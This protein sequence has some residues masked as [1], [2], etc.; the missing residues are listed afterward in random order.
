MVDLEFVYSCFRK[1]QSVAKSRPYRLP[2]DWDGFYN[3]RLADQNKKALRVITKFF[4]T[5]WS[6]IDVYK[7][8]ECGFE[9]FNNFSYHHFLDP[10]VI[11]LY[12]QRDKIVKIQ[13]NLSKKNIVDSVKFVKQYMKDNNIRFFR[14]YCEKKLPIR[15]YIQNK[16]DHFFLTWLIRDGL[17]TL[18]HDD[19]SQIPYIMENYRETAVKLMEL[20]PFLKKLKEKL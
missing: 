2:K 1:T 19:K 6:K 3:N 14:V 11:R 20:E 18:E 7:Y 15:H 13:T 4:N 17:V 8:F 12:I 10:R 16:I 9:L 5:K